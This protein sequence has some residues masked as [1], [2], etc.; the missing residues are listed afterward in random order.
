MEKVYVLDTNVIL[1]DPYSMYSFRGNKIVIPISVVEEMDNFKVKQNDLGRNARE[2]ARQMDNLMKEGHLS[3]GVYVEE[4]DVTITVE[5]NHVK[6]KYLPK[7]FGLDKVDNRI[8][9]LS[10]YYNENLDKEVILISKDTNL[11][12]KADSL[13]IKVED[14]LT[15][16]ID[17]DILYTGYDEIYTSDEVINQIYN[18]GVKKESFIKEGVLPNKFF[19]AKSN[20]SDALCFYNSRTDK[21][22][23]VKN[24][25]YA[26]GLFPKN[27]EQKFAMHALLDPDIQL[28]TLVGKSGTGKTLLSL[29]GGLQQV[30]SKDIYNKL[31]ILRPIVPMGNDIGYLPG[32]ESEK[33]AA[34]MR[35]IDDNLD[36]LLGDASYPEYDNVIEKEALT[37]IR[38]R[39]IPKQFIIVDEAQNLSKHEVKTIITRVGKDTKV[40]LTGDP[41]QIDHPYLDANNNGLTHIVEKMKDSELSATIKLTK[42]ERSE[43]AEEATKRL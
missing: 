19:C 41:E 21:I 39:S 9:A 35:P 30:L 13:G 18:G 28:I 43:L 29:A 23:P 14:Y 4:Y 36:F 15:D 34:W 5:Q 11:R 38:G 2:F 16:V 26:Q 6:E 10:K 8:L 42:G 1:H 27:M 7:G 25:L 32:D 31:A 20:S 37:F 12:I 3:E 17:Y 24:D 40:V 33:L 22:E